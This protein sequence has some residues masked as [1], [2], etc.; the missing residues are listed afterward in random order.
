M[1]TIEIIRIVGIVIAL[2]PLVTFVTISVAMVKGVGEDDS[3]INALGMGGLTIFLIGVIMLVLAYLTNLV[4]QGM[5]Q[6]ASE[7]LL[8]VI[9]IIGWI[10]TVPPPLIFFGVSIGLAYKVGKRDPVIRKLSI[11]AL[12]MFLMGVLTAIITF[13]V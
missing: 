3:T 1:D 13:L 12:T 10:F 8:L 2:I 5:Q 7:A 11:A 4:G 9:K 6:S